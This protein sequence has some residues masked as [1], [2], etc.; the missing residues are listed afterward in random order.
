MS[1]TTLWVQSF[2]FLVLTYFKEARAL[3]INKTRICWKTHQTLYTN[4][5]SIYR[6]F[7]VYIYIKV[8]MI[9]CKTPGLFA[10]QYYL[11]RLMFFAP[12]SSGVTWPL[13]FIYIP[14][15]FCS[16]KYNFIFFLFF[17]SVFVFVVVIWKHVCF[18]GNLTKN[19]SI[20]L[21]CI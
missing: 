8:Y 10:M 4:E 6:L 15:A 19:L 21:T 2:F 7:C 14:L 16:M 5:K 1:T 3:R 20:Y 12:G 11:G 13:K 17:K 18:L 9:W